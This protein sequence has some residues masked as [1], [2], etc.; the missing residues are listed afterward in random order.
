MYSK[1]SSLILSAL[2]FAGCAV[3]PNYK[4]PEVQVPENFGQ[5]QNGDFQKKV[6]EIDREW[7]KKFND[8][9]LTQ[10]VD[11]AL[12]S[13][14][15]IKATD[16][17]IDQVLGLFDQSKSQLYPRINGTGSFDR[18][19]VENS[20]IVNQPNGLRSTT[21]LSLAMSYE[22]DLFG[23]VRRSTEAAKAMLLGS[24][25]NKRVVQLSVVGGVAS[26]YIK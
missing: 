11:K 22:I 23:K 18:K 2:L 20:T 15:D 5:Q 24:E 4:R 19:G 7:W 8:P 16:A 10:T 3:G 14:Y 9:L 25:Y 26:S 13:N 17:Q 21:S 1:R 6:T 12:S